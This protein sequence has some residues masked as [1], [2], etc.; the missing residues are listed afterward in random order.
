MGSWI[1]LIYFPEF[2]DVINDSHFYIS[3]NQECG[4]NTIKSWSLVPPLLPEARNLN[5]EY[6]ISP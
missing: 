1:V 2:D 4:E 6:K 5:I 3:E